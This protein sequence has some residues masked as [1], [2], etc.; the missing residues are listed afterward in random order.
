MSLECNMYNVELH[1]NF[2]ELFIEAV[3]NNYHKSVLLKQQVPSETEATQAINTTAIASSWIQSP[4]TLLSLGR[5]NLFQMTPEGN[6]G[7]LGTHIYTVAF[8]LHIRVFTE[9]N[10]ADSIILK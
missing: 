6:T 5:F 10:V 2:T 3:S 7:I 4:P 9:Q 1:R 8:P